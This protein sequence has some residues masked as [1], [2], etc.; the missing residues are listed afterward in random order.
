MILYVLEF[1]KCCIKYCLYITLV[2]NLKAECFGVLGGF[3]LWVFCFQGVQEQVQKGDSSP[4]S[5]LKC[6]KAGVSIPTENVIDDVPFLYK[7]WMQK[8]LF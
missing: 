7:F 5:C 4:T 1:T 8:Q 3:A 2:L 6:T